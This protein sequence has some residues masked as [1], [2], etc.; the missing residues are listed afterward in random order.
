MSALAKHSSGF[1]HQPDTEAEVIR[2]YTAGASR[3]QIIDKTGV[4]RTTITAIIK[5]NN[6]EFRNKRRPEVEAEVVR[7]YTSGVERKI[8]T[9][10]TGVP[11]ATIT[12]ILKRNG[13]ERDHRRRNAVPDDMVEAICSLFLEGASHSQI[14]GV[15]GISVGA[16]AGLIYRKGLKR[17]PSVARAN[18]MS[19]ARAR[20]PRPKAPQKVAPPKR[21]A[22]SSQDG[23][24][25]FFVPEAEAAKFTQREP[26]PQILTAG[27]DPV[28]RL[29]A[30]DCRW[31]IGEVGEHGFRFCCRI[32]TVAYRQDG[33]PRY[34]EE[35]GRKAF[36]PATKS[37]QKAL[38][39]IKRWA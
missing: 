17:D 36:R 4:G 39:S 6:V 18:L 24:R 28:V 12:H 7:L 21:V 20:S 31:P 5:R 13:V 9:A 30:L 11:G 14:A 25:A 3:D 26:T 22:V 27:E 32:A 33:S 34:C 23:E 35:H 1:R 37:D 16:V 8:I 19:A 10:Q 38:A 15:L 29:R 2:L